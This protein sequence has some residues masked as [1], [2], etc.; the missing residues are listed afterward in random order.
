MLCAPVTYEKC[1]FHVFDE[2][3][4]VDLSP[5]AGLYER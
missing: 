1:A 4:P 2:I 5:Q 3:H